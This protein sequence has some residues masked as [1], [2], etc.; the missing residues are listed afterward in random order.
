[1]DLQGPQSRR[2]R[3]IL[4]VRRF[5]HTTPGSQGPQSVRRVSRAT[6]LARCHPPTHLG[7]QLLRSAFLH[8]TPCIED[9]D[10]SEP[11]FARNPKA[12]GGEKRSSKGGRTKA[13]TPSDLSV[14][15]SV[16]YGTAPTQRRIEGIGV[17]PSK[18]P[19][20][21]AESTRPRSNV[22]DLPKV[23]HGGPRVDQSCE[24][25]RKKK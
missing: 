21:H 12:R 20:K 4:E 1:M 17:V 22:A 11:D 23:E 14:F 15:G 7:H 8:H 13:H 10:S 2:D 16:C 18:S 5:S 24:S 3:V 19:P 9:E 6:S 25:T